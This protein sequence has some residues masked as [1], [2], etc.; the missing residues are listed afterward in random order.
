MSNKVQYWLRSS[1]KNW[2][3]AGHLFEK[4]DYAYALFFGNLTL[5]K[6]LKA[7]FVAKNQDSPPYSHR[8]VY[9]AEVSDRYI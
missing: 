8:L 9:L 5:E 3:V 1:E 4:K 6:L 7:I 2:E